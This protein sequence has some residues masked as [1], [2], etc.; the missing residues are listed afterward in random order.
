MDPPSPDSTISSA[1]AFD[2]LALDVPLPTDPLPVRPPFESPTWY[3]DTWL[4]AQALRD[5]IKARRQA[6]AK[7]QGKVG[8]TPWHQRTRLRGQRDRAIRH[9]FCRLGSHLP[10]RESRALLLP[11]PTC[12]QRKRWVDLAV[13]ALRQLQV[14]GFTGVG[15]LR[16]LF[17][18]SIQPLK[19]RAYPMFEYAG[20]TDLTRESEVELERT[21]VEVRM[22]AV[23]KNEVRINV[24]LANHPQPRSLTYN[25]PHDEGKKEANRAKAEQQRVEKREK[26][27]RKAAQA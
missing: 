1:S 4:Y 10:H 19:A 9:E 21:E 15:V 6:R 5:R 11:S 18:R 14:D 7:V 23:L 8:I 16:T 22:K 20:P 24:G 25:P 17:E 2:E 13:A 27:R 26:E 12:Q 3:R